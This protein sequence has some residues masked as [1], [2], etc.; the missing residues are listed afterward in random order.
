M[1]GYRNAVMRSC[2]ALPLP[3][4]FALATLAAQA[5]QPRRLASD[6]SRVSAARELSDGTVLFTDTQERSLF[7]V[8]N[9]RPPQKIGRDGDGPFEYRQPA[10]LVALGGDTTLVV[11][12]SSRR[13]LMLVG[14]NFVPL[15]IRMRDAAVALCTEVETIDEKGRVLPLAGFAIPRPKAPWR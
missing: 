9:G 1:V 14:R 11:D 2:R 7:A 4:L 12:G 8:A 3:L 15:P 6:L 5:P 13:W 10:R